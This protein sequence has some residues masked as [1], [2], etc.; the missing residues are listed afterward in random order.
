MY[1]L[2]MSTTSV[3]VFTLLHFWININ[4]PKHLG[5]HSANCGCFYFNEIC[6][7]IRLFCGMRCFLS[8]ITA[9]RLSGSVY[10][11]SG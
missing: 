11:H 5:Q 8:N 7:L 1:G 3:V 4:V 6:I 9:A 10:T 2:A